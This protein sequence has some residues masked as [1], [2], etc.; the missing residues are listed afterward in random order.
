MAIIFT[1]KIDH[2]LFP[3]TKSVN[4]TSDLLFKETETNYCSKQ[5]QLEDSHLVARDAM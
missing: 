3:Y 2:F 1:A 4:V 5:L